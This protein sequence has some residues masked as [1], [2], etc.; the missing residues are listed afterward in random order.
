MRAILFGKRQILQT[1]MEYYLLA[2][3][4]GNQVEN[5]GIRIEC[6]NGETAS[7]HGITLSQCHILLLMDMILRNTV[8]PATLRDVV[9]DWLVQQ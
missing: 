5:Y 6:D 8:T 3:E 7:V 4:F 9:D 1:Q 2:D